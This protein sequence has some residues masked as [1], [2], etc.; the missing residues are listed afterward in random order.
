MELDAQYMPRP[1]IDRILDSATS[2]R[3]VYVIAGAGYGKTQAVRNYI[4]RQPDAIVR[5][6][7]LTESDDVGSHYW[8]NLVHKV[9]FDNPDLAEKLRELGFP[10][11]LTRFKQ[12][13]EIIRGAEHRS[14]RTFLVLDD[15]HLINSE[16]SLTFA[17]RCAYLDIPGACV[18]IISR[19]EPGINAVSLFAK[20]QARIVT[21]D[22][23]RF[24]EDEI[25]EYL[26]QRGILCPPENLPKLVAGTKGWALAIGLLSLV[27][28]RT[29]ENLGIALD[30]MKQNIFKLME[31][32]AWNGFP[33]DVRKS[34]V[35]LSLA[36]DL[37]SSKWHGFSSDGKAIRDFP[38]LASFMWFDG[39]IG[40]YRIH[41]LYLEFLQSK[42]DILTEGERRETYKLAA[43]WCS[44]NGFHMDAV[45][46]F[47]KSRQ[48]DRI[49][50]ELLSYPYKLPRDACEY[51]LGI[52]DRLDGLDGLDG[53]HPGSGEQEDISA[54]ILQNSYTPLLLLW[55]DRFGE[56]RERCLRTIR[57][58][59]HSDEPLSK[60]LIGAAYANLAYIGMYTCTVTHDYD[61]LGYL[62]KAFECRRGA[63]AAPAAPAAPVA[64][65]GSFPIADI[66][67]FA[68]LI[69]EGAPLSELD[70]FIETVRLTSSYI[71][72]TS[73][74][75]YYGYDDLAACEF[76]YFRNQL[77]AAA[78]HARQAFT[79]ARENNQHGIEAMAAFYLF[80]IALHEGDY[81][82]AKEILESGR[83]NAGNHGFWNRRLFHDL[84]EEFVRAQIGFPRTDPT[85]LSM[86]KRDTA[87][88]V[89][90]PVRELIHGVR[91]YIAT[92]KFKRALALLINAYPRKP[93]E[94]F[95]LGELTLTV[96]T[97]AVKKKV[98][99]AEGAVQDFAKAYSLSC[100]GALEMPFVELG[101]DILPLITAS[102]ERPDGGIPEEWLKTISR[103]A[104]AYTKRTAVLVNLFKKEK[105]IED[106]VS[107]SE[108]ERE[109]L[110]DL[111]HGL[112]REEIS[113]SRYLSINTVHK[114]VQSVYIKLNA[115][116]KVDA[117]RIALDNN[118]IE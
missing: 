65:K 79:K 88:E 28:K 69:G 57:K 90:V 93:H 74:N 67:S 48:Y 12:F 49:L 58:W 17:E 75:T 8:E 14:L 31:A 19:K 20:N 4:E 94:R 54:L 61:F 102:L 109:V 96:L 34:L 36:A 73:R 33:Q 46:Y 83:D 53:L 6:L 42:Q 81:K 39:F 91:Y 116:N 27:L 50:R 41:P 21:E 64:A 51:Y 112:S 11:T 59:E 16:Q 5:W 38:E 101:K 76:A 115:Y 32:E 9:F 84:V 45:K 3:L 18:V 35:Q 22:E 100:G 87:V 111:Y 43:G 117:I 63:P 92:K 47:A 97:A 99:D 29:P 80:H 118:L 105:K 72:E 37:P 103:K 44:E 108:R 77:D 114:A 25:S 40:D 1:R 104:S 70:Q 110:G 55:T 113:A 23:L 2:G 107:L 26:R 82:L 71:S 52:L 10:E 7:Q 86:A 68:C 89:S 106:P 98:G 78:K 15:F 85:W 24:T 66:R 56:A 30:T 13:A 95:L 60:N 62:R